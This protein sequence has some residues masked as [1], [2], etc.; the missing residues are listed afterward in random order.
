M[1]RR[2]ALFSV[3]LL[4]TAVFA[5][6]ARAVFAARY[7]SP[8]VVGPVPANGVL[9]VYLKAMSAEGPHRLHF[10]N[11]RTGAFSSVSTPGGSYGLVGLTTTLSVAAGDSVRIEMFNDNTGG[12]PAPG[13]EDPVAAWQCNG[14]DDFSDLYL[15]AASAGAPIIAVQCWEDWTDGDYNDVALIVSYEPATVAT[16]TPTPTW[17]PTATYTPIP[18]TATS[19]PTFTPTPI[20]SDLWVSVSNGVSSVTAGAGMTYTIVVGNAGPNLVSNA[21]VT[22]SFAGGLNG[23]TWTCSATNGACGSASGTGNINTTVSLNVGGTATFTVNATVRADATGTVVASA[24]VNTAGGVVESNPS[25]NSAADSDPINVVTDLSISKRNGTNTIVPGTT[26]TYTIVVN[27]AG[28]SRAVNVPVTDNFSG[29][30]SS[31]NWTC[32]ATSGSCGSASGAGEINATVTL[33]PGG[34]ATFTAVAVVRADATGTLSNSAWLTV[35]PGTTDPNSSDQSATDTDTLTPQA[36]LSISKTNGSSSVVPG[37]STTYTIVVQNNGPSAVRDAP[38]T[39]NFPVQFTSVSWMCTA[40]NGSCGA[41]SGAGDINATVSLNPGGSATFIATATLSP[42]ATGT[43]ANSATVAAPSGVVDPDSSD[44]N[45]TDSDTLTP[46]ADVSITKSA[47]PTSLAPGQWVTYTIV[48]N[49]AGPSSA[50]SVTV[51]DNLSPDL[52]DATWTCA[53]SSGSSCAA[54]SGAGSINTNVNLR[55]G[56]T[57]TFTLRARVRSTATGVVN[58]VATAFTD[59]TVADPD[60]SNNDSGDIPVTLFPQA[61]VAIAKTNGVNAV[62]PGLPVTYTIVVNNGGPSAAS[63]VTVSDVIPSQLTNAAWTCTATAGSSC[64]AASGNGSINTTVNLLDDGQATFTLVGFV[65]PDAHLSAYGITNTASFTA[66]SNVTMPPG[67]DASTDSD[68]YAP[69]ADL[70]LTMTS[71]AV[72]GAPPG[73]PITQKLTLVNNGPSVATNTRLTYT[74]PQDAEIVTLPT[75]CTQTGNTITCNFGTLPVNGSREVIIVIR[76]NQEGTLTTSATATSDVSDP[77]VANNSTTQTSITGPYPAANPTNTP[78]VTPATPTAVI[79]PN[80]RVTITPQP[81][82]TLTPAR[83]R[84]VTASPTASPTATVQ[85]SRTAVVVYAPPVT[86][87]AP[88]EPR[89][90]WLWLYGLFAVIIGGLLFATAAYLRDPRPAIIHQIHLLAADQLRRTQDYGGQ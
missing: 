56:G 54:A 50:P 22:A 44:E 72:P 45:A 79:T 62:T 87:P 52:T 83:S 58:N 31:V 3:A 4:L 85:P 77:V 17:T 75:G 67:F 65:P 21:P 10:T 63:G 73:T 39:D 5:F 1:S 27:N 36:D 42:D 43:V 8:A 82:A 74:L 86:P 25:N 35:P 57:A 24:T 89:T 60:S 88:V 64:G 12:S 71:D 11:L 33:D 90:S 19:T 28:P 68:P 51:V 18:P 15:M 14:G 53:A 80:R 81:T 2:T 20:M 29:E 38:V 78:T 30:F 9:R 55:A 32:S 41:A 59:P 40:M 69:R 61:G 6:T 16:N 84:T 76:H 13:Y 23:M 26:T 49:N 70:A 7:S 66:P 47:S 46:Q 48:V 34:S 37:D